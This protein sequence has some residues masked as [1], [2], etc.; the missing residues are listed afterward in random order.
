MHSAALLPLLAGLAVAKPIAATTEAPSS[1]TPD[2]LPIDFLANVEI[3]TY[4][5][6]EGV[7]SQDIPYATPTAIAAVKADQSETPLSV[8]PAATSVAINAA[9]EDGDAAAPT[10]TATAEKRHFVDI[11]RRA[12]CDSQATIE[13]HYDIDVSSASAF[14]A[15]TTM[16]NVAQ[17]ASVPSG[18]QNNFVNLQ[19]ASSAYAY[20]GY[21]VV[22]TGYDVQYCANQCDSKE[23]CL[24][25]NIYF[26]RDP[27]V[28]PGTGCENPPAF[29]NV[30]CSFW[31]SALDDRTATN[32]GQWRAGF[33]V[34]IA[35][36]NAYTS[37]RVGKTISGW[38]AP[39]NLGNAAM[40][41]PLWDAS[42]TWTYM[43]Y[44][45]FQDG[46][47]DVALCSAA[48]EAQTAYNV[49]HPPSSGYTPLCAGFGTY[50][51]T[52]TDR[53]T[54]RSS[55]V[56]Q[57]CTMYTSAWGAEY[58]T[59]T[60]AWNDAIM[61]KYTYSLSFFYSKPELQPVTD[62]NLA[63]LQSDGGR[64]CTSYI[65]YSAPT[66][67]TTS[68]VSPVRTI[69]S[70][71]TS[72]V[73]TTSTRTVTSAT[74]GFQ[75]RDDGDS[76]TADDNAIIVS[77]ITASSD[78]VP[79]PP[80]ATITASNATIVVDPTP[81]TLA[82]RA[83]NA[84]ATPAG[85]SDWSPL[86]ISAAC[87]RVATGTITTTATTTLATALTT[88]NPTT[89]TTTTIFTTTT[90][91][92]SAPSSTQ[93]AGANNPTYQQ[94]LLTLPFSVSITGMSNNQISL[95]RNGWL[96]F[97]NPYGSDGSW[98]LL[99]LYY[100]GF[101]APFDFRLDP[102]AGHYISARVAGDAP[103]R[104]IVFEYNL[105]SNENANGLY[106]FDLTVYESQGGVLEMRY[107][108]MY[109][110]GRSGWAPQIP[111]YI[112]PVGQ[113]LN[114]YSSQGRYGSVMAYPS[115]IAGGTIITSNWNTRQTTT[116]TF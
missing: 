14:R 69:T 44:K 64:F 30:K 96:C 110:N 52:V 37:N 103:N 50:Q 89:T 98:D 17:A 115:S 104:K 9:G 42:N 29:A 3:P 21:T 63:A 41:A 56:G 85:V 40:N 65:S 77:Y 33:E 53:N 57:M 58:A 54:G 76:A 114:D 74:G 78:L 70:F 99:R 11:Q 105:G 32:T 51:L 108:T 38:S 22:D 59:N 93:L 87:S 2:A 106:H 66:S 13:S 92:T 82:K 8:F 18:Y 49:A 45:L 55:V 95:D 24:S 71:S 90:V 80:A 12:A 79:P 62:S 15:D 23:G 102:A 109:N 111:G 19:G 48:C 39:L 107:Y 4:S 116:G 1:A 36:S 16:A 35:G 67:T 113:Q 28:E 26:E 5:T 88:I 75:R 31:G 43:G 46:P 83:G 91:Y 94:A 101:Y 112:A 72:T 27:T 100:Q 84:V 6:I 34:A 73:R 61:T 7:S 86:K 68:T 10:S 47:F 25:F 97:Q 81:T 60:V 20:L